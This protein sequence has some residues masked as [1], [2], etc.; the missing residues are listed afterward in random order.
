[1]MV[2]LKR[3]DASD[4]DFIQLVKQLDSDLAERDGKEHS[5]YAQFNKID[6]LKQ[7]I[8]LYEKDVAI[9][10]GAIKAFNP[11]VAEIK[12]MFVLP[13]CR[14]RGL[15]TKILLEL[16]QWA[17]ELG[18]HSCIL[19]TGKRQVEAIQ[20]Y[21]KQGFRITPNYGQYAGIENS[22]CFEKIL[23]ATKKQLF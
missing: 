21:Q 7:V 20:L 8:V 15:A 9:G 1:M 3:T 16:Q 12:R 6:S 11:T 13:A 2:Y 5:F 22:V 17:G 23:P 10:C 18:F 4:P 14:S 19:E